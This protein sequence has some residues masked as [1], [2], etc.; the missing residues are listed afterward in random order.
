MNSV[1]RV[2]RI[3]LG[4]TGGIAAYKAV[5]I[6]RLMQKRG[7]DVRVV[8]TDNAGYFVGH[9]TFL[10]LTGAP[11]IRDMFADVSPTDAIKHTSLADWADAAV[12]APASANIIGKCAHGIADDFLSTFLMAFDKPT[13]MAPAMNPTMFSSPAVQ[14]N[15]SILKDRGIF[16]AGPES[17]NVA[18]GHV[19]T[20]RMSDP[21]SITDLTC[22]MLG[23]NGDCAGQKILV[24]AGPTREMIDPVRCITNRS[25]GKMGYALAAAAAE[26]GADVCLISGPV[27]Q[28]PHAAVRCVNVLSASEMLK[29]V[30]TESYHANVIVMAAAV[31]DWRPETRFN[32]KLKKQSQKTMALK[33]TQTVD[34]LKKIAAQ[35]SSNQIVI[36]FAAE[37]S[38]LLSE[39]R[40]KRHDK[41]L[42]AIVVNDIGRVETGFDSEFNHAFWIDNKENVTEIPMC[43]KREMAD[44]ILD[45]CVRLNMS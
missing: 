10:A 42:D 29:A 6:L 30:E 11:V 14:K 34:V 13:L 19:G 21:D 2:T 24:T 20:G 40:R 32:H 22:A 36:G 38:D 41:K 7:F 12:I 28:K 44:K 43:S 23:K 8:M 33:L 5:E 39:G 37:T 26:R 16:F 17:G 3:A 27:N 25:S 4:I 18:C 1:K 31:S 15:L 45:L 35:K 9:H